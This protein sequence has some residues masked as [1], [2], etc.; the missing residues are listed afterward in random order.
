MSRI[1]PRR[2]WPVL[3]LIGLLA[4]PA[5]ADDPPDSALTPG[6]IFGRGRLGIQVQPMTPELREHYG[7]PPERG[8]LVVKVEAG[9]PAA[10]AGVRVGDVALSLDGQAIESPRQLA[11]SVH[12][13]PAGQSVTLELLRD[14]ERRELSILPDD[15]QD[16]WKEFEEHWQQGGRELQRRLEDLERRL[17]ELQRSIEERLRQ[18]E[19]GQHQ[20]T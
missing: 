18:L 15:P 4:A 5:A 17:E 13:V 8:V 14:G 16:P 11:R 3:I 20:R 9:R 6:W 2:A 12:R 19:E 7:A 1:R 10:K